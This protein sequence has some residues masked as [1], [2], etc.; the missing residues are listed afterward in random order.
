MVFYSATNHP[1]IGHYPTWIFTPSALARTPLKTP[2]EYT[3]G[4]YALEVTLYPISIAL[5]EFLLYLTKIV[6]PGAVRK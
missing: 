3:P 6:S 4:I 2:L 1:L 5:A